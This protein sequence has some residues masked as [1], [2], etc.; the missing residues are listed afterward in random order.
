MATLPSATKQ[1]VTGDGNPHE[2]TI[3]LHVVYAALNLTTTVPGYVRGVIP[4]M[5]R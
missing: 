3:A 1:V 5:L 2:L 4:L